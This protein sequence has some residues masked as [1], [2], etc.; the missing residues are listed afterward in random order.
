MS[1]RHLEVPENSMPEECAEEEQ[2]SCEGWKET[3][4]NQTGLS[5]MEV[6]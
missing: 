2:E 6:L 3:N 5:Q 4:L 1:E